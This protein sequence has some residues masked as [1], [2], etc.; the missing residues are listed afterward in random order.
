MALKTLELAYHSHLPSLDLAS[1]FH[2][3][4]F[5]A[6]SS[7]GAF[8]QAPFSHAPSSQAPCSQAPSSRASSSHGPFLLISSSTSDGTS[9]LTFHDLHGASW[10]PNS[11]FEVPQGNHLCHLCPTWQ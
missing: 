7:H 6:L 10:E 5:R 11:A 1:S 4:F 8:F 3:P 2:V 9:S